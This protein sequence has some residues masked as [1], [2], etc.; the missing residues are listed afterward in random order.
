[1]YHA[2]RVS[3]YAVLISKSLARSQFN[4]ICNLNISHRFHLFIFDRQY[5]LIQSV[6]FVVRHSPMNETVV[7][8]IHSSIQ[9]VITVVLWYRPL[10]IINVIS[11]W[12]L[13]TELQAWP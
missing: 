4:E 7:F 12:Y 11:Y 5:Y 6:N 9:R 8:T 3:F 10:N 2:E 13:N 1:M